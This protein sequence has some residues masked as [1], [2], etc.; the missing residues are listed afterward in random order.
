MEQGG[1]G[2]SAEYDDDQMYVTDIN[3]TTV[4]RFRAM[5]FVDVLTPNDG[6][7]GGAFGS[8]TASPYVAPKI[9]QPRMELAS[10]NAEV[11][12]RANSPSNL[13]LLAQ[14]RSQPVPDNY[15]YDR[16]AGNGTI[17]YILDTGFN[18]KHVVS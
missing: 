13:R 18:W 3:S 15:A 6:F 11:V 8:N 7:D 5:D 14:A 9:I 4:D 12:R 10:S 1:Y 16:R 2:V 17:I